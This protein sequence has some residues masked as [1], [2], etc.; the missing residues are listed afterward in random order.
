M[1]CRNCSRV[2]FLRNFKCPAIVAQWIWSTFLARSTP[3]IVSFIC[4]PLHLAAL[5][6]HDLGTSRC[7]LGRAATIPS[8][9]AWERHA[10]RKAEMWGAA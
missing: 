9:A 7:R 4:R 5:E 2:S 1:N 8:S 3:I 6:H 10:A